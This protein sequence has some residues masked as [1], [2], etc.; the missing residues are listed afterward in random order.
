MLL[1]VL[2]LLFNSGYG[3]LLMSPCDETSTYYKQRCYGSHEFYK[4]WYDAEKYCRKQNRTLITGEQ[5]I[6]AECAGDKSGWVNEIWESTGYLKP[7]IV[8]ATVTQHYCIY[9]HL[10]PIDPSE[11]LVKYGDCSKKLPIICIVKY[12]SASFHLNVTTTVHSM[13]GTPEERNKYCED[14][15]VGSEP[16]NIME[17]WEWS[18]Y[19][20][21]LAEISVPAWTSYYMNTEHPF[22]IQSTVPDAEQPK[23]LKF[24]ESCGYNTGVDVF[25][26][27]CMERKTYTCVSDIIEPKEL[28]D[29][30]DDGD[31]NKPLYPTTYSC[32][33]TSEMRCQKSCYNLTMHYKTWYEANKECTDIGS[34]LASTNLTCVGNGYHTSWIHGKIDSGV[35]QINDS[36]ATYFDQICVYSFKGTLKYGDCSNKAYVICSAQAVEGNCQNPLFKKCKG[37]DICLGLNAVQTT[38]RVSQYY[39][40]KFWNATIFSNIELEQC[41]EAI[42]ELSEEPAWLGFSF[43]VL[44]QVQSVAT[45]DILTQAPPLCSFMVGGR[46][47]LA[48]CTQRKFY[49]CEHKA[50]IHEIKPFNGKPLT[51]AILTFSVLF[52]ICI[53]CAVIATY[54][55]YKPR[56]WNT[57][58]GQTP[59][60]KTTRGARTDTTNV[61]SLPNIYENP[62]QEAELEIREMRE[63]KTE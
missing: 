4:T 57:I 16:F 33:T 55:R 59:R 41:K 44:R 61:S 43:S 28:D 22:D 54:M 47:K 3:N 35:V 60:A 25:L 46:L 9:T 49:T 12:D 7:H 29:H 26:S 13:D 11:V 45:G 18:D 40:G 36:R 31:K 51:A 20:N 62:L 1:F 37:A 23:N 5:S 15:F 53:N 17:F 34:Q 27:P 56:L 42:T 52:F 32:N 63:G 38:W 58:T 48:D 24:G 6:D 21:K 19:S 14:V 2:S 50:N 39:C 10:N 8:N 30:D